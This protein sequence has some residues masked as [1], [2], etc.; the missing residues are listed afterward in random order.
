MR[1][2]IATAAAQVADSGKLV[3]S[4]TGEVESL[5]AEHAEVEQALHALEL[6]LGELKVRLET[7]VQ[8][9]IDELQLD[10]PAKYQALSEGD[11]EG[12]KPGEVDWDAVAEE[13]RVLREKIQRLGNVN[14]DAISEQDELEKRA[15]FLSHQVLDL[16]G[17]KKQLEDLINEINTESSVRFEATFN[18]VREHFQ[19]MFRKLFG[20]GKADIFLETRNSRPKNRDCRAARRTGRR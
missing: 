13:I 14:L 7:L 20:G 18:A 16:T 10:L 11:G 6:R 1:K 17:S 19:E 9:T 8:R 15:E 4:L 3:Q 5:R 2:Q 12:Y